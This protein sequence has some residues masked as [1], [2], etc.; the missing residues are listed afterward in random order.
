MPIKHLILI[1]ALALWSLGAAAQ[2]QQARGKASVTWAGKEI[3]AEDRARALKAAQMN[4]VEFYYAEAGESAAGN[5]DA[6]R[7]RVA[8]EPDRFIL[9]TTVLSE[10]TNTANKQYSVAVR[11]SLNVSNLRNLVQRNSAVGTATR[12][13]RSSMAFLF[14]SREQDSATTY[15]PRVYKRVDQGTNVGA[16][17]SESDK[18]TEG[19]KITRGR[20]STDAKR[21]STAS[22]NITRTDTVETGGSVKRRASE[23]TWRLL[24]SQNLSQV[25]TSV[26]S[27]AGFKVNEAAFIEPYTQGRFK[28]A[29]V[30]NDYRSG[31]DLQS[32]TLQSI[33]QGMQMAQIPYIA[34]GTLDVGLATPDP[35]TGLLRVAVTVNARM[36]D[37]TAPIP[38]TIASVGPVQYSG[39]GPSEME[40]RNAALTAAANNAARDLTSQ[41]T[42]IGLR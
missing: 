20:V 36:L 12:Q 38:D 8:A 34:L 29:T 23:T 14:V 41:L 17:V 32:T 42:N 21:D 3:K 40:A 33:V 11:V 7:D 18:G 15:D 28:V 31:N 27:R 2:V 16:Q 5:Y 6:V 25:F 39:T 22:I 19:E 4:A 35:Q 1:A 13:Q 9:E 37:V 24:P 26:F 30:E 10:D